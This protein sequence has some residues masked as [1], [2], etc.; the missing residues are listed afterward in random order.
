MGNLIDPLAKKRALIE[1]AKA[2][3][4]SLSALQTIPTKPIEYGSPE[5]AINKTR[6]I[7]DNSGSMASYING[8]SA[9]EHAKKGIVEY[10]RSSVP[11]KDAVAI[12][13]MNTP[14]RQ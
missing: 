4:A 1:A 6:L 12:H 14:Y 10:L 8:Q 2:K 7:A 13:L 11:N 9:M 5:D 3:A